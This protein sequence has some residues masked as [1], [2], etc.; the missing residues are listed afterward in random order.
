[1][2]IRFDAPIT[3]TL[4]SVSTPSSSAKNCGTMVVSTSDDTPD[5]R[6]RSNESISSMNTITGLPS[7]ARSRAR[8]KIM[9]INRSDSPTNLLS[10]SGPFTDRNTPLPPAAP[11]ASALATALAIRVLPLPGGP[12]SN[13]PFGGFKSYRSNSSRC[14]NGI[15]TASRIRSICSS[16]PP[17]SANVTSGTSSS[18][19][20][21]SFCAGTNAS[22]NRTDEST[23]TRSATLITAFANVP[24]RRINAT[25][26]PLSATSNRPSSI[27]CFTVRTAP[28]VSVSACKTTTM[29]SLSS[30]VRPASSLDACTFA[31]TGTIMR[32][33]PEITSAL[34]CCTPCSSVRAE[35][36]RTMVAKVM[37]G[38]ANWFSCALALVSS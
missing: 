5:P 20:S 25:L 14:R 10:S 12:Y 29:F 36:T 33:V 7:A 23:V 3:I 6:V 22:A 28:N 19:R 27:T 1:M 18:T 16:K 4:S 15:C 13:T 17:M 37:G 26:P 21:A 8:L 34:A 35:Y 9:R 24:E 2:S 11:S 30:T 38:P 31:A 32:R